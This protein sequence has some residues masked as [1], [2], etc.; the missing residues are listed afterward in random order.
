[1][2]FTAASLLMKLWYTDSPSNLRGSAFTNTYRKNR[3]KGLLFGLDDSTHKVGRPVTK[4]WCGSVLAEVKVTWSNDVLSNDRLRILLKSAFY[5]H[6]FI[7]FSCQ[8]FYFLSFFP[9]FRC[10]TFSPYFHLRLLLI[11]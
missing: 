1:M 2:R 8:I 6:D 7:M 10:L 3:Y 9:D 4:N 5:P 11:L